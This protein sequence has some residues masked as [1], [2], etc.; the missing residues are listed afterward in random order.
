MTE[1]PK[2][3]NVINVL[4]RVTSILNLIVWTILVVLQIIIA[5]DL[6]RYDSFSMSTDAYA[7]VIPIAGEIIALVL[8]RTA[9]RRAHAWVV[10][11]SGL[12]F[13][14][15]SFFVLVVRASGAG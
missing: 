7:I 5:Y 9:F 13:V 3:R 1:Q 2:N 4:S 8:V 14:L 6:F 15:G 10:I 12:L 11:A